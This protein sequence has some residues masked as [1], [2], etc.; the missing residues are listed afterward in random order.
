MSSASSSL[1]IGTVT[2]CFLTGYVPTVGTEI[3][4]VGIGLMIKPSLILPLAFLGAFAQTVSKISIYFLSTRMLFLLSYKRKRKCVVLR[5]RF[6]Q[7]KTLTHG[8]IF[9]SALTGLP[10]YY[11]I[12]II[13]GLFDTGWL[14]FAILGLIGM[15]IRFSVCLA[16]P[17]AIMPFL[18]WR[19]F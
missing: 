19:A 3:A 13:C 9:L 2:M 17:Q 6:K 4:L 14:S 11:L 5:K 12:N 10:P 16:F 15:F 18:H 1:I 7:K 8:I